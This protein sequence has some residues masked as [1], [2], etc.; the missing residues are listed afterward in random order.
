MPLAEPW[1][2]GP[3]EDSPPRP[4]PGPGAGR[5]RQA[6]RAPQGLVSPCVNPLC[7]GHI[8]SLKVCVPHPHPEPEWR[9]SGPFRRSVVRRWGGQAGWVWA[10]GIHLP[11]PG[12]RSWQEVVF[13]SP[14]V[15]H[16][17]ASRLG[18]RPV[19]AVLCAFAGGFSLR[20]AF[21]FQLP[22][23]HPDVPLARP[24]MRTWRVLV[25]AE[26]GRGVAAVSH[27]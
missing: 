8:R 18:P 14:G 25:P 22:H 19:A 15:G 3:W 26:F 9:L 21:P 16:R 23:P 5:I 4:G 6:I 1:G 12:H 17:R 13:Y 27:T 7:S 2:T 10:S 24:G 20:P 11:G